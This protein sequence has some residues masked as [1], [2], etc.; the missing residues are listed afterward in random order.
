MAPAYF[1]Y[2]S[3]AGLDD[4][5]WLGR[6]LGLQ[7]SHSVLEIGCGAGRVSVHL[8]RFLRPGHYACI[9]ADG[10]SLYAQMTYELPLAGLLHRRPRFLLDPNLRLERA[11]PEVGAVDAVVAF[12]SV[13]H[14]IPHEVIRHGFCAA[15]DVL[16]PGGVFV[17]LQNLIDTRRGAADAAAKHRG[18]PCTAT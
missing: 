1:S 6:M 4:A 9:E 18:D 12:A 2:T 17:Q 7:P 16:R 3:R 13:K 8:I 10:W 14:S 5:H 11:L 15:H